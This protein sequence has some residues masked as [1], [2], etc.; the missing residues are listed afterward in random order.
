[1]TNGA[2]DYDVIVVGSGFGGSVAAMRAQEKGY[3]TLVLE[4]GKR[5]TDDQLP[6]SSWDLPKFVW[7]PEMQLFGLQRIRYLDDVI[8]L[9]GAA[10]GGGSYVYANTLYT[11]PQKF[12]D[13]PT[14]SYITDWADELAPYYDQANRM[15]GV[16]VSPYADTDG[17]R[18]VRSVAA[19]M[20][21]PYVRAP[22]GIYFGSPGVEVDDPYFGGVGPRRTGCVSTADCMIG[23][24]YG[25]KNKLTVNYLYLAEHR[26]AE[27]KELN[28]VHEI[29]ALPDGGY[30]VHARHPGLIGRVERHHRYTAEQVVVAAH[31]YGTAQILFRMRHDGK[32]PNL[33]DQLGKRART[34]SEALISVQRSEHDFKNDPERFHFVPGTSS[35]TA[36]IKADEESTMGPVYYGAG[37]NAMSLAYTAQTK[38]EH[39]F[40]GWLA[41]FVKH[42]LHTLSV[43]DA[44]NWSER[45]FNMLCMR[46]HDDWLDLYMTEG[47]LRSKPGSEGAPPTFIGVANDVAERI[48]EKL[49]GRPAQT[50]FAVGNRAMSSHFVGGMTIGDSADKGVVD[51]YQRAFGH[52][53]LHIMDGSVIAANPG[54]NPSHTIVAL[55]ERAMSFW[56]NKGEEDH[57]PPLGS[58]YDRVSAVMPH[59]P[60][61]P[62]GAPAEYRIEPTTLEAVTI[63]G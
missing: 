49:G 32:L 13:A 61:V 1:M 18:L 37:S 11:P 8:V 52:P 53:G 62:A 2:F 40:R 51:P 27:I 20:G 16:Q 33:S 6:K 55:A 54:V 31:A 38:S 45:G 26:G 14:W 12:F 29:V 25:A 59:D 22:L 30:E 5:W 47:I 43:D 7:Q 58:G 39:E 46:D 17:D 24:P 34:N 48:A 28:E 42:P 56:P 23:C 44:R 50:W 60:I 15:F 19:D 63:V 57:R 36:A 4:A 21:R 41:E 3:R 35:V 9:S 10:L